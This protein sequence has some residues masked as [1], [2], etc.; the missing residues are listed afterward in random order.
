MKFYGF[1]RSL[2][3][4]RVRIALNIKNVEAEQIPVNLMT[5]QQRL[6][7]YRAI[8]PQMVLPALFDGEGATLFQSMAILEYLEEKY[9]QP[10]MLPAD[11]RGRARVRGLAQI[12]VSDSHPMV[13]P[14]IREYLGKQLHHDEA[15]VLAWAQTWI[16]AGLSAIETHLSRDQETGLYCHGDT[17]TIADICLMSLTAGNMFFQGNLDAF[18]TIKRIETQCMAQDA[19][20]RAHPLRQPGAPA[21]V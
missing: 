7:E 4:Y 13:V 3:A 5:G 8:N 12:V 2:A 11:L 19:F 16:T 18:P 14:R 10:A 9:P 6:D 17:A 20:A 15:E 1:W 21:K